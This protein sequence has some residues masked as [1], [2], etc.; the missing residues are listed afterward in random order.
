MPIRVD[1]EWMTRRTFAE[2]LTIEAASHDFPSSED[3]LLRIRRLK[4]GNGM[5]ALSGGMTV[6]FSIYELFPEH[7][8]VYNFSVDPRYRRQSIGTQ[9][10][11]KLIGKLEPNRRTAITISIRERNDAAIFFLRR[12]GFLATGVIR[13]HFGDT[14]EDAILF[15]YRLVDHPVNPTIDL[16]EVR[17]RAEC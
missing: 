12:Q 4:N 13:E 8:H 11:N 7:I 1:I 14:G 17:S 9:M 10:T 2:V 5:V 3:D 6:G 16:T 15:A